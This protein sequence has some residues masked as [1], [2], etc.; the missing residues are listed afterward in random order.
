MHF[1]VKYLN[2]TEGLYKYALD[3]DTDPEVFKMALKAFYSD[4]PHYFDYLN[5]SGTIKFYL[6]FKYKQCQDI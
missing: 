4:G 3:I 6:I 1:N 5:N 2:D